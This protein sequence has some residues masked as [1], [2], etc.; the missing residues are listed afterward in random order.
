MQ[1]YVLSLIL[2][3]DEA[4]KYLKCKDAARLLGV[5]YQTL[6]LW[7]RKNIHPE[8]KYTKKGDFIRYHIDDIMGFL[9]K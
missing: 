7:R 3:K 4:S 1:K 9:S 5:T 8:L 2:M 6:E